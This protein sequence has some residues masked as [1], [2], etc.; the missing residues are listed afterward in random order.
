MLLQKNKWWK[1]VLPVSLTINLLMTSYMLGDWAGADATEMSTPDPR[2]RMEALA[3]RLAPADATVLRKAYEDRGGA[4]A[5]AQGDR[6]EAVKRVHSLMAQPELDVPALR[7]AL[8]RARGH[9]ERLN[10]LFSETLLE[11]AQ[12]APAGSRASLAAGFWR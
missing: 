8:V 7:E 2:R 4:F 3:S 6:K 1:V 11:T 5:L 12:K 10:D 9:S